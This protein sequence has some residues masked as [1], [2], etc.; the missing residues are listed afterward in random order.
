MPPT[1]QLE[2]APELE[3][4]ISDV[5]NNHLLH[6]SPEAL[7][8]AVDANVER[9]KELAAEHHT[10]GRTRTLIGA[11]VAVART[12]HEL[13]RATG[14]FTVEKR[15]ENLHDR[16]LGNTISAVMEVIYFA[17]ERKAKKQ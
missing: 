11:R 16:L 6:D 5:V 17:R 14:G 7:S 3:L 4:R 8:A 13:A 9:L 10:N 1:Q 12:L 15:T 2:H